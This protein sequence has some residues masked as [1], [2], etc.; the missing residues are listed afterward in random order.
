MKLK[1][2][3]FPTGRGEAMRSPL[4][5]LQLV[6][7]RKLQ[8]LDITDYMHGEVLCRRPALLSVAAGTNRISQLRYSYNKFRMYNH[9]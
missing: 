8:H 2:A 6:A 4:R 5:G 7:M 1:Y 3:R 9:D